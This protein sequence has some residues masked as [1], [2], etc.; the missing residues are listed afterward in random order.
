[1]QLFLDYDKLLHQ[2]L[3]EYISRDFTNLL[4]GVLRKLQQ[5]W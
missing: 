4:L 5:Q 1:M 3:V 2:K